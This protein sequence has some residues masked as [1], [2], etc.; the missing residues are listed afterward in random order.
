MNYSGKPKTKTSPGQP[1]RKA[2]YKELCLW[3][4]GKRKRYTVSG[5]SMEPALRAGQELLAKKTTSYKTGDIVVATA[6]NKTVIKRIAKISE[7]SVDLIGDN[8]TQSTDY[9]NLPKE[10]ILGAI[11]A[12][13]N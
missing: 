6:N 4:V 9:E 10:N 11:T 7:N 13:L 3:L 12:R 5:V 2:S 1:L 8:K